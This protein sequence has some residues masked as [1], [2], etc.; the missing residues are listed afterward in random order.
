MLGQVGLELHR[1]VAAEKLSHGDQRA[2]ELGLTLMPRP[3]L[4][5]L[6]EPLAGVG[7]QAIRGAM[8]LLESV[9]QGRT[10]L[11]I[12]H[13]MEAVMRLADT[14]LVM[15]GGKILASGNPDAVRRDERVRAAYLGTGL[16]P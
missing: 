13:N 8:Q 4:L 6:D 5:L 16:T 7:H 15:A 12:E 3:H 11:L 14:V 1:D 10:V 9:I 2:L